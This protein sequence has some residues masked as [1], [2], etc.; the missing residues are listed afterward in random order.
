MR[1]VLPDGVVFDCDGTIG[2][3][4][5]LS[6]RAWAEVLSD[7]GYQPR[8]SDFAEIIGRPF[9]HN[10]RHFAARVDLGDPEA[11]FDRLRERFVHHLERDLV[12]YDDAV[13]TM[14]ALARRGVPLAVASS[15]HGGHVR[16]VL[17]HG[18][19]TDLVAAVVGAGEVE[20]YKPDPE[21]YL[22]AAQA[23]GLAPAACVA[24]EDT[25]VGVSAARSA[26]MFT[27]GIVRAH[28]SPEGLAGAH[29]VVARLSLAAVLPD[30]DDPAVTGQERT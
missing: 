25:A 20:R 12:V 18:G 30:S 26:G 27:V 4:E 16:R 24:V 29:R 5:S 8:P 10:W 17:E 21:P 2:D 7:Y 3:T 28:G 1:R 13:A 6:D 11:F 9:E 14:R 23:L 15:S 22:L 19:V